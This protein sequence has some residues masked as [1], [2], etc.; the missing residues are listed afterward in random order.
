MG[1]K[2]HS[3][4][5]SPII[6]APGM[7]SIDWLTINL[8]SPDI[9]GTRR[10]PWLCADPVAWIDHDNHTGLNEGRATYFTEPTDIRTAQFKVVTYVNDTKGAKVATVWSM[11]HNTKIAAPE[12]M[13]VQFANE[14]LYTGEW[15]VLAQMFLAI[16]CT[17]TG[18]SRIDIAADGIE[19][20]GGEF[21]QVVDQQWKGHAKYY[22]KADWLCRSTR[23]KVIGAEFGTRSS[24]KFIRA[25]KKKREM[26]AK[27]QKPH[28]TKAWERA[29]GFDVWSDDA[30][31]VNRFEIQLKGKEIRRYF[32]EENQV[33]WLLDCV[34]PSQQL[35]LFASTAPSMFDFRTVAKRSRDAVPILKWDW[36]K[37]NSDGPDLRF[38]KERA[39]SLSDHT[40]KVGLRNMFMIASTMADPE[41][42]AICNRYAKA[43]G[44][45]YVEWFERKTIEW[46]REFGKLAKAGD[47]NAIRIF[48]ALQDPN[49]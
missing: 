33:G 9:S 19:G 47:A 39:L 41:G 26:K 30:F 3:P 24:N 16:G 7:V 17:Y 37:V 38:R 34:Q 44:P 6:L 45:T 4:G 20:Q 46:I 1:S 43:S 36:T 5:T 23:S 29:F 2:K 11:P 10:L 25:Y 48:K 15:W 49:L 28:I 12:W 31:E 18:I 35:D 40:I 22:G 8:R 13:Q 21:P 14:T 32:P 27:G 42:L